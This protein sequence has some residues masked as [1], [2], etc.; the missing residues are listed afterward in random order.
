M[1]KVKSSAIFFLVCTV[2]IILI[3]NSSISIA[4]P[5]Q[6]QYWIV[7]DGIIDKTENMYI[8]EDAFTGNPMFTKEI[9]CIWYT[10]HKGTPSPIGMNGRRG[11]TVNTRLEI[12]SEAVGN[13]LIFNVKI[14]ASGNPNSE[15]IQWKIA[16]CGYPLSYT[17]YMIYITATASK[18]ETIVMQP[19]TGIYSLRLGQTDFVTISMS[20]SWG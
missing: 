13:N 16:N 9:E 18:E 10:D 3:L 2:V 7:T 11:W 20:M 19:N 8:I 6:K 15:S 17:V 12:W 4:S 5:H 14:Y 1:I